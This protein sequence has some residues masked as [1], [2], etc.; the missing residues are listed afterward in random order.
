M[1]YFK[2]PSA[3]VIEPVVSEY[4]KALLR[5]RDVQDDGS[6]EGKRLYAMLVEPAKKLIPPGSRVI[7]LPSEG[8]YGLNFETL[9]VPDPQPHFAAVPQRNGR[10]RAGAGRLWRRPRTKSS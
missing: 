1:S 7:V 3:S 4:R 8:L 2:L 5:M 6:T 9:V 10:E